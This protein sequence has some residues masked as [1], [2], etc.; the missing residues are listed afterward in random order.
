MSLG[1]FSPHLTEQPVRSGIEGV[2]LNSRG[3]RVSRLSQPAVPKQS[4]PVTEKLVEPQPGPA[5]RHFPV[6]SRANPGPLLPL[7]ALLRVHEHPVR[8]LDPHEASVGLLAIGAHI[9][10]VLPYEFAVPVPDCRLVGANR[11]TQDTVG[12]ELLAHRIPSASHS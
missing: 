10:V 9:G 7:S 1:I 6:G 11:Q 4:A 3:H 8:L 12:V 2:Q 5:N